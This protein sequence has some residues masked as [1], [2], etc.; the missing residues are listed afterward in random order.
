MTPDDEASHSM[1]GDLHVRWVPDQA[2]GY[3]GQTAVLVKP[4]GKRGQ[5]YMS[6]IRPFRHLIVYPAAMKQ[7]E[8]TRRESA[9]S[10]S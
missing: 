2:G 3:R 4:N 7:L 9:S 5:A 10:T 8:P 1:H 6:A